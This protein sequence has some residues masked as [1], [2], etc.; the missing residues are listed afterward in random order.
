MS[1]N[2]LSQKHKK[3]SK[4]NNFRDDVE[5]KVKTL[6]EKKG[7]NFMVLKSIKTIQWSYGPLCTK[8]SIS[9]TVRNRRKVRPQL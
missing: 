9:H 2:L 6:K 8:Y 5:F 1:K 4:G 7:D 3:E